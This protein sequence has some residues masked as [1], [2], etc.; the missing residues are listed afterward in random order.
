M[1]K[2]SKLVGEVVDGEPVF[3][4]EDDDEQYFSIT[5]RF[6]NAT[7]KVVFSEYIIQGHYSGKVE[8][9]GYLAS[10][11]Q[12][13]NNIDFY[14]HANAIESVDIDTPS[15]NTLQFTYKVT[16]VG[17]MKANQR[18][19]DVLP[20]VVSDYT[21]RQTTSVLY[22]CVR[23]KWARKL[24]DMQ[25]GYYITGE[26]Y[27]KQYRNVYEVIVLNLADDAITETPV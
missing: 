9:T 11:F 5:V 17:K 20:L 15:S 26:G 25:K 10:D 24:K 27:L 18:G 12:S 21:S 1:S 8:V 3:C 14:L 19:V 16:K 23:G 2:I 7:I 13:K 22:L 4:F 6:L